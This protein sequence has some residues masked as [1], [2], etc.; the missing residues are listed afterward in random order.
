MNAMRRG[1][2]PVYKNPTMDCSW[3]CAFFQMCELHEQGPGWE[4]FRDA[5]FTTQDPYAD[6]RKSA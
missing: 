5:V 1:E 3:D 4:D 6:H 2:L